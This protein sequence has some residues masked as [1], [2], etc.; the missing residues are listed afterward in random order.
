MLYA[1]EDPTPYQ[2]RAEYYGRARPTYPNLVITHLEEAGFL[3]RGM[4]IADIGAG[5]GKLSRLF[6]KAGYSIAAVEP[7]VDMREVAQRDLA[8]YPDFHLY[9]GSSRAIP[10]LDQSVDLIAVGQAFHWFEQSSAKRE[11]LRVLRHPKKLVTV[12]NRTVSG[13]ETFWGTLREFLRAFI[14]DI[15]ISSPYKGDRDAGRAEFFF[16]HK[17]VTF[18]N[19][20]IL[21]FEG[22]KERVLSISNKPLSSHSM[23]EPLM[24]ALR[25]YFDSHQQNGTV[26]LEY[27]TR[28]FYGELR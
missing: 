16:R 23:H 12:D 21:D 9:P 20:Q 19:N 17:L 8:S 4:E 14:I 27:E 10:L 6:L 1:P 18:P 24:D 11:F 7:E 25:Q 15:P 13:L 22:L 3:Q 2:G 5:T 26:T 28:V